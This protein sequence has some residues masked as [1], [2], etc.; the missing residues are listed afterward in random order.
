MAI[1]VISKPGE[2][3]RSVKLMGNT[4]EFT[5]VADATDFA[6][7]QINLAIAEIQRIESVLTTFN[8]NSETN[9]INRYA[10]RSP[11]KFPRKYITSSKEACGFHPLQT[12]HSI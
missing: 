8:D 11:V 3:R 5:I 9:L 6:N 1:E 4:F 12:A 7:Q 10:G 2:F